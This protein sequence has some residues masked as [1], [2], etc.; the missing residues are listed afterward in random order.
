MCEV[1]GF[2]MAYAME[3]QARPEELQAA[4][5]GMMCHVVVEQLPLSGRTE[6]LQTLLEI[7][8]FHQEV[9]SAPVP[10]VLPPESVQAVVTTTV[11]REIPPIGQE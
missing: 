6:A 11:E 5:L 2:R 9:P 8:R 7:R 1:P 10:A 4:V 3:T